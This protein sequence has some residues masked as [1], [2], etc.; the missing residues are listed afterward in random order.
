M[1]FPCSA[2]YLILAFGGWLN[3]L[4]NPSN[5]GRIGRLDSELLDQERDAV[6]ASFRIQRVRSLIKLQNLRLA[7]SHPTNFRSRATLFQHPRL[8]SP[9][10]KFTG[11]AARRK[12]SA[13]LLFTRTSQIL[14]FHLANLRTSI[15]YGLSVRFSTFGDRQNRSGNWWLSQVRC[16][17]KTEGEF[18]QFGLGPRAPEKLY[19]H[20]H[21]DR[22][23]WRWP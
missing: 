12:F 13:R 18:Y 10:D 5:R 15:E 11:L 20:R 8:F 9:T 1:L 22:S 3:Q 14:A 23:I 2:R 4:R 19:T 17:L 6:T 7:Y 21:S 16:L